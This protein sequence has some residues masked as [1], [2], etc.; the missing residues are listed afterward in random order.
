M[1]TVRAGVLVPQSSHPSHSGVVCALTR[2]LFSGHPT[3]RGRNSGSRVPH[4]AQMPRG[5]RSEWVHTGSRGAVKTPYNYRRQSRRHQVVRCVLLSADRKQFTR[6]NMPVRPRTLDLVAQAPN[7]ECHFGRHPVMY[8]AP[9]VR[10]R[11]GLSMVR[12]QTAL[13]VGGSELPGHSTLL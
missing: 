3:F 10:H 1:A 7:F 5:S 12:P 4:Y 8:H 11:A 2:S 9:H 6:Q 13:N